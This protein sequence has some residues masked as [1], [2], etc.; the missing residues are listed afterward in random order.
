MTQ[1]LNIPIQNHPLPPSPVLQYVPSTPATN[2]AVAQ[3]LHCRFPHTTLDNLVEH[4]ARNIAPIAHLFSGETLLKDHFF[5]PIPERCEILRWEER[6]KKQQETDEINNEILISKSDSYDSLPSS[7]LQ[8]KKPPPRQPMGLPLA[9]SNVSPTVARCCS[10]VANIS[11]PGFIPVAAPNSITIVPIIHPI[12]VIGSYLVSPQ[13]LSR[14]ILRLVDNF[15]PPIYAHIVLL[16]VH[17]PRNEAK[18]SKVVH[19]HS[20]SLPFL[21]THTNNGSF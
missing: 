19:E 10:T 18:S 3:S 15:P 6:I 2:Q 11:P 7:T 17:S 13:V 9:V 16:L 8:P 1:P 12:V 20:H 4:N 14:N 21:H 5:R